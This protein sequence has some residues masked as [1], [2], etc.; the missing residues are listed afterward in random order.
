MTTSVSPVL[1]LSK[2]VEDIKVLEQTNAS[3]EKVSESLF[4]ICLELKP[5]FNGIGIDKEAPLKCRDITSLEGASLIC[6]SVIKALKKDKA[7]L[8]SFTKA[9]DRLDTAIQTHSSKARASTSFSTRL[10]SALPMVSAIAAGITM[11]YALSEPV[12]LESLQKGSAYLA[13]NI[14]DI[15]GKLSYSLSS[16]R[17]NFTNAQIGNCVGYVFGGAAVVLMSIF[18]RKASPKKA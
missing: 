14:A 17:N 12:A 10:R 6:A 11:G 9:K 16:I 4:N 8:E 7:T 18:N 13:S 3:T 2:F 5:F 15:A 1:D